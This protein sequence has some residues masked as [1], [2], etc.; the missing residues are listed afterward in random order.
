MKNI[1]LT[2]KNFLYLILMILSAIYLVL[3]VTSIV[4]VKG[5]DFVIF[6]RTSEINLMNIAPTTDIFMSAIC[7]TIPYIYFN[8]MK[9]VVIS[10]IGCLLFTYSVFMWLPMM[11]FSLSLSPIESPSLTGK[12]A[13]AHYSN[14]N[15]SGEKILRI[16]VYKQ[17]YPLLYKLEAE[18]S[19]VFSVKDDYETIDLFEKNLYKFNEDKNSLS[20]GKMKVQL[21]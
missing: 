8:G 21:K 2:A 6:L 15:D 4:L 5:F 16:E 7:F 17:Q 10:F 20:Y 12:Y 9:R 18:E 11:A 1:L 14:R 13:V 19:E 3:R